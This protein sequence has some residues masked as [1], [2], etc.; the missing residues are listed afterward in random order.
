MKNV[1]RFLLI[2]SLCLLGCNDSWEE[3]DASQDGTSEGEQEPDA[4]KPQPKPEP[5]NSCVSETCNG[6]K[7]CLMNDA[8]NCG[9]CGN[10]CPEGIACENGECKADKTTDPEK[11][12]PK[13]P[14][15]KACEGKLCNDECVDV[16]TDVRHCGECDHACGDNQHCSDAK[17]ECDESL[18]M[19]SDTCVDLKTDNNNCGEC[20]KQCGEGLHC[21]DA[22]CVCDDTLTMCSDVCV[23]LKTDNN[24]C[25]AC[26]TQCGE[27]LHCSDAKCECNDRQMMCSDVC[28]D[29]NTDNNNCGACGTQCGESKHCSDA[30]CECDDP[31]LTVCSD[32][33]VNIKTDKNNCG[34]CG[35]KCSPIQ[36][37]KDGGCK[38]SE[39]QKVID[40]AEKFLYTKTNTC[41]YDLLLEKIMPNL[42]NMSPLGAKANYGYDLNCANFV[43]TC[44]LD[45]GDMTPEIKDQVPDK[46]PYSVDGL[47]GL[48]NNGKTA[49]RE[50]DPKNAQPGDIWYW[51]DDK[52]SHAELIVSVD[53]ENGFFT[54]IGSNNFE[55]DTKPLPCKNNHNTDSKYSDNPGAYQRVTLHDRPITEGTVCSKR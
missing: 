44:L 14:E 40:Y 47:K 41:T 52:H 36:V 45:T 28:V 6:A 10:E 19:C 39:G 21:S 50:I 7:V 5:A 55:A 37:C 46:W 30:K 16:H 43:A 24:N 11:P 22:K 35:T 53:V 13:D 20:G 18:T 33:C 38:A 12:G 54:Q 2:A 25:G 23:D 4:T 3:P 48:C 42:A 9:K 15:P 1:F 17:C 32:A 26:G 34:A 29:I 8:L 27:G 49:Y 31:A 51:K